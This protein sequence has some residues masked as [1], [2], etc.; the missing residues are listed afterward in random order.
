VDGL[1]HVSI[2][3]LTQE[4]IA[5]LRVCIMVV[6]RCNE[7]E[8]RIGWFPVLRVLPVF[9]LFFSFFSLFSFYFPISVSLIAKRS[10]FGR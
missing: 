7:R 10:F 8:V 6:S 3:C 4:Y 2:D 5:S 9:F 1:E